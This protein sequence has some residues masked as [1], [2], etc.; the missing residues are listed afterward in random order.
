VIT[1]EKVLR[2]HDDIYRS[3][4]GTGMPLSVIMPVLYSPQSKRNSPEPGFE[5]TVT[6]S[7]ESRVPYL[8]MVAA[9]PVSKMQYNLHL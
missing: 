9:L 2:H 5:V 8:L 6:K 4:I 3:G 1:P 7:A